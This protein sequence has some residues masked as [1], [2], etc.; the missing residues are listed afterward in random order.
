MSGIWGSGFVDMVWNTFGQDFQNSVVELADTIRFAGG[1]AL[2]L[3][4]TLDD[5]IESDENLAVALDRGRAA[6]QAFRSTVVPQ[7]LE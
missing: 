5:T 1:S 2:G 3:R 4:T 6:A 7:T